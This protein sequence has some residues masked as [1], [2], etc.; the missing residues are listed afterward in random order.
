MSNGSEILSMAIPQFSE[1][2][3]NAVYANDF[4]P[5]DTDKLTEDFAPS[6]CAQCVHKDECRQW[7]DD[8][9]ENYGIWGGETEQQRKSRWRREGRSQDGRRKGEP[10]PASVNHIVAPRVVA[11]RKQ[12]LSRTEI[13]KRL[14]INQKGVDRALAYAK[15]KG[16]VS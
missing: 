16:M 13:M 3:C 14:G 4:F 15:R 7:A 11:L 1:A 5:S 10:A 8:H 6:L 2:Q 12:G 9:K